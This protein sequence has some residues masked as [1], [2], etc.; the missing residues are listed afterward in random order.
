[1]LTLRAGLLA[2]AVAGPLLAGG[3]VY[4][5]MLAH[6]AVVVGAARR[7]ATT[8]ARSACAAE[9]AADAGRDEADKASGIGDA[10]RAADEVAATPDIPDDI[11]RLCLA[12]AS[13][14][15]RWGQK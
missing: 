7:A 4:L 8:E 14:R 13:C 9:R 2:W 10:R 1:M 11:K 3:G 12:S 6:E 5:T 15:E